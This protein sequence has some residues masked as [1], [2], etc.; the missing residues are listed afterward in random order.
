MNTR[1]LLCLM[2]ALGNVPGLAQTPP[3]LPNTAGVETCFPDTS[4]YA[5]ITV[6]PVGRDFSD[7]QTAINAATPGS[8]LVLDAGATFKGSFTLPN[9]PGNGW[10]ILTSSHTHLLP[11]RGNAN[12]TR[13]RPPE[14][15]RSRPKRRHAEDRYE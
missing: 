3:A 12:R 6:G 11:A 9:K 14:T 10:I 15:A 1:I 2:V 13:T 8:M 5:V 7:L 4:G